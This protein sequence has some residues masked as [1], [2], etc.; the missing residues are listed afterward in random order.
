MLLGLNMSSKPGQWLLIPSWQDQK[1]SPS[2]WQNY[3]R[4]TCLKYPWGSAV[5]FIKHDQGGCVDI[6]KMSSYQYR[7]HHDKD[8]SVVR[9]SYLYNGDPSTW[10]DYLYINSLRLRDIQCGAIITPVNFLKNPHKRHTHSSP[11]RARYGMYFVDSH[12]DL[13]YASGTAA[14]MS[15]VG[16]IMSYWVAL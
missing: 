15:D 3:S 16:N 14:I 2:C 6:I 9:S 5:V 11:V 8:K 7:D 12:S 1:F 10:K 13:H 4:I